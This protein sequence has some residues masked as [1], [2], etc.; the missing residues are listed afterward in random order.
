MKFYD[1]NEQD[2]TCIFSTPN[3][4]VSN[5]M[6]PN[7]SKVVDANLTKEHKIRF[8]KGIERRNEFDG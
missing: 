3:V 6:I 1:G 2:M 4:F 8:S 7:I 5:F